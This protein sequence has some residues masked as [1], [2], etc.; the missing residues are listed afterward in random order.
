MDLLTLEACA[1]ARAVLHLIPETEARP[2]ETLAAAEAWART[3]TPESR[4]DLERV[5]DDAWFAG[6]ALLKAGEGPGALAA[7][8]VWHAAWS[9]RFPDYAR[10]A[11][12]Y[13]EAAFAAAAG[14]LEVVE[15]HGRYCVCGRCIAR[16]ELAKAGTQP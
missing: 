3:V 6:S 7:F 15:E 14:D 8:A 5:R 11:R 4:T 13:A 16:A 12:I 1:A 10:S 9:Y 2:R